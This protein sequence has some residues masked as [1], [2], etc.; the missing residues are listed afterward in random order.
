M[1]KVMYSDPAGQKSTDPTGS[2]S[3]SLIS[4]LEAK[5]PTVTD[6]LI[7]TNSCA[8]WR[9]TFFILKD[10]LRICISKEKQL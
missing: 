5:K 9:Q 7:N 2:G 3:S 6:I 10:F 4:K 1:K 8:L